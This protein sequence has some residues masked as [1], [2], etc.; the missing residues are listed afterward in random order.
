MPLE[1]A[2]ATSN[3]FDSAFEN[4]PRPGI[5]TEL[6]ERLVVMSKKRRVHD[7][8]R[9]FDKLGLKRLVPEQAFRALSVCGINLSKKDQVST[10]FYYKKKSRIFLI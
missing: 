4:H 7:F 10:T 9:D 1:S 8:L 3:T 2:S 6:M 5:S